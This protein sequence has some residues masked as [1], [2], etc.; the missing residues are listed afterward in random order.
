MFE[1]NDT[2]YVVRKSFSNDRIKDMEALKQ[3]KHFYNADTIVLDHANN[4]VILAD[5][6][7]EAVILEESTNNEE[8]TIHQSEG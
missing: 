2:K 6:V 8:H 1:V 4:L 5:T 7:V 3:I